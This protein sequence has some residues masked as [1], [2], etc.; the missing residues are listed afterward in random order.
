MIVYV[1]K[2]IVA[3]KSHN[4]TITKKL[5]K[6]LQIGWLVKLKRFLAVHFK[7]GKYGSWSYDCSTY[8]T[9]SADKF[10]KHPIPKDPTTS[11]PCKFSLETTDW[12]N[13]KE[14]TKTAE[15][16][17]AAWASWYTPLLAEDLESHTTYQ[18]CP[19]SWLYPRPN[20]STQPTKSWKISSKQESMWSI[21][22]FHPTLHHITE[23][24]PHV[25]QGVLSHD[26]ANKANSFWYNGGPI[27]WRSNQETV[28]LSTAEA[29]LT[30]LVTYGKQARHKAEILGDLSYPQRRNT[31]MEDNR[32][33][34]AVTEQNI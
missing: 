12:D 22:D 13:Y 16:Y 3:S 11:C 7:P 28:A 24:T 21:I 9:R 1:D 2:L 33:V 23:S 4:Q 6:H 10:N 14:N 27:S 17:Q 29:E 34:I 32:A 25:M 31:I 20:S 15:H 5:I 18:Q 19:N 26:E 30:S 8:M